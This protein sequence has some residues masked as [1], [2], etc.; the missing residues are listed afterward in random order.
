MGN[1][2][3]FRDFIDRTS[4]RLFVMVFLALAFLWPSPV[5]AQQY[6]GVVLSDFTQDISIADR[7]YVIDDTDVPLT[8][9][10]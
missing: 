9:Q 8:R 10:S 5:L 2:L 3:T 1:L 7:Y 4:R 6:S